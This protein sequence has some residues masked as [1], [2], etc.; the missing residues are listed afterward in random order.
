MLSCLLFVVIIGGM[1]FL[2][3]DKDHFRR[4]ALILIQLG[5]GFIESNE[6]GEHGNS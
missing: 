5:M 1:Y 2:M 4:L 6:S 3:M